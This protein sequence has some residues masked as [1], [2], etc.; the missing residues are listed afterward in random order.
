MEFDYKG[1]IIKLSIVLNIVVCF[2]FFQQ[3]LFGVSLSFDN[4]EFFVSNFPESV[5]SPGL[6]LFKEI[7]KDSLRVLYHHK[8]ISDSTLNLVVLI[9]NLSHQSASITLQ[10]GLG[11]STE[12]VVFAGHKA[13]AQFAKQ[14]MG[15]AKLLDVPASSSYQYIKHTIKPNQTS[16]GIFRIQRP[17]NSRIAVKVVMVDKDLPHLTGFFDTPSLLDQYRIASFNESIRSLLVNFNCADVIGSFEVGG[18]PYLKDHLL[19]YELK[20]NYGLIYTVKLVLSNSLSS[21]R[22]VSLFLSPKKKNSVDRGVV[23]V[24]GQLKEIGVLNYKNKQVMMQN[25]H[26]VSL[27]PNEKK[28]IELIT[29][30]QSGCFYPI[31]IIMKSS[32]I[33]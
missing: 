28:V 23:I 14:I 32:E 18:P 25:F 21:K 31:D 24:D 9:Y 15:E 12:D 1:I 11:G 19:N 33:I 4:E 8:N 16:S 27:A 2:V 7:E 26:T 17:K 3:F 29:F 10:K 22:H 30:P 20:G 5:T 13:A 6:I